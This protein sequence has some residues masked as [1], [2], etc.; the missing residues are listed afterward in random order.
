[1]SAGPDNHL[2]KP[3]A[4]LS[5]TTFRGHCAPRHSFRGAGLSDVLELV[6]AELKMQRA[7]L[8][9][10]IEML[11]RQAGMENLALRPAT[12]RAAFETCRAPSR[13]AHRA[14]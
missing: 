12:V 8:K 9:Q 1:M 13:Q 6:L 14:R 2:R 4:C 7:C 3:V 10:R 5:R 11:N